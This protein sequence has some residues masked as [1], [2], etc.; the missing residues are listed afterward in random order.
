MKN[1]IYNSMPRSNDSFWLNPFLCFGLGTILT[2]VLAVFF[3][4]PIA[5]AATAVVHLSNNLFKVFLV[6]RYVN[7]K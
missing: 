6:G 3:P 1:G 5:V 4:M 7:K 2:P